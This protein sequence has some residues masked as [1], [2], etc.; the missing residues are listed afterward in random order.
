SLQHPNIL[1][2]LGQC[3]ESVPFL[4][5][6]EFCQLGD[7]KRYLRAQRKSDGMTPDLL[8]R[9]LLTLQRMAYE[10][11]SGLLHLHENNYIHSDLALRNCLLTSD[12]TVRIGDYGLSHNQ[13]K[14]DYYLTPDKLWIPLRWIAPELLEEFRGNLI[15]TDQT[16]T[17]N[18]WSLGVVIWELF[19][20]GAQPHRHL[21][22]EE[23]LTFVIR[24]RQ[25]TLA[26]PRLKLTHADYWYEVMQSCWLPP[27][28]RPTVNKVFL[29]LSSL[30]AAEQ[31]SRKSARRDEDEE[32]YDE[33][34]EEGR[35]GESDE[36]FERR[37]DAL[38]PPAF[39]S[40]AHKLMREREYGR[41]DG[42]LRENGN[43]F[44][45]LDPVDNM[46]TPT[47]E[48]D[49]ILTVTETSKG[50]NFEYFWEKAH[51]R[52]GY[53]PLPPPQP[54]PTPNS[55]HRQ[56][57]DTPTVVPVISARSPSLASEYY[58]RLE[59]HTPQDKSP[60]L[61]RGRSFKKNSMCP[62]DLELVELQTGTTGKD[63]PGFKQQ[64]GFVRGTSQTVRSSEVK[65][66][67]PNTGLVEFSKESCNRVTDY[68]VIDIGEVNQKSLGPQAPI[69]PPKPRSMSMS[70]GSHLHSRP[71][72]APPLGYART[73]GLDIY[74]GS[75]F[76]TGKVETSDSLLMSSL[77]KANF[78]HLGIN[79]THQTLPPSPSLSPSIPPS[80]GSHTMFLP[81]QTCPPPL[82]PHYRLQ[83]GQNYSSEYSRY[84]AMHL[85]RDPLSCDH[86][87]ERNADRGM[88]RSQSL[89]NS[90]DGPEL[91]TTDNESCSRMTRSQSTI[92]KIERTSSSSPE[93]SKDED[94]DDDD[95]SPFMSPHRSTSGTTIQHTNLV[96]EPDP[97]TS[98]LFSR[99]MKR[100]QSRLATILPA[101]WREDAVMQRERV[102]AARKSPIH[103]FLT[104]ISNDSADMKDGESSWARE[105]DGRREKGMRRSQSLLSELDSTSQAWASD[106][107]FLPG[108]EGSAKKRDLFLTEIE[109]SV[110]DC[111]DAYDGEGGTPVSRFGTTPHP[112]AHPSD[113]PAYT[114]AEEA[115]SSG[116][117]K[118]HSLLSEISNESVEPEP[119]K[120]EITREEFLKEIQSAET[121]LTEIITRQRKMEESVSPAPLSPEYESIC[122]DPESSQTIQFESERTRTGKAPGDTKEAIYAQVTKRAKR[123]E[124]KVAMRPEI[125][126]LQIASELQNLESAQKVTPVS[127]F[128]P[129]IQLERNSL[130][131]FLPS[132]VMPKNGPLLEQISPIIKENQN[133]Q[134]SHNQHDC[135]N[136]RPVEPRNMHNGSMSCN[137]NLITDNMKI[138]SVDENYLKGMFVQ[139]KELMQENDHSVTIGIEVM[140]SNA[141]FEENVYNEK[142]PEHPNQKPNELTFLDPT[143]NSN[144]VCRTSSTKEREYSSDVSQ[145]CPTANLQTE[146]SSQSLEQTTLPDWETSS[147]T[148]CHDKDMKTTKE[149]IL[150]SDSSLSLNESSTDVFHSPMV[151]E[152]NS[153]QSLSTMTPS[154]SVLS[155]LTS[156]SLDC[157]TPGDSWLGGGSGGWRALGTETPHRDSAYFSDSDLDGGEGLGRK[158]TDVLGP[159][160]P[161]GVRT[162]ERGILMGIE[163]KIEDEGLLENLEKE[164][165]MKQDM[166]KL[167]DSNE[168]A[169]VVCDEFIARLFSNGEDE[170]NKGVP[171]SNSSLNIQNSSLVKNSELVMSHTFS[172]ERILHDSGATDLRLLADIVSEPQKPISGQACQEE[173]IEH[174][175]YLQATKCKEASCT[176]PEFPT[177]E[178]SPDKSKSRLSRFYSLQSDYSKCI[179]SPELNTKLNN[180]DT[181]CGLTQFIW[182][183][184]KAERPTEGEKAKLDIQDTDANEL[185][186][187]NLTY[188]EESEDEQ[189]KER[190][191]SQLAVG[192]LCFTIKESPQN[193]ADENV[194]GMEISKDERSDEFGRGASIGLELKEKELWSALEED[195]STEETMRGEFNCQTFQ[196]G[197]LHLWP[198]ENDQ[199]AAAEARTPEAGLGSELFPSFGKKAWGEE[200]HLVVSHEFWESEANDELADSESHP[201]T[202]RICEDAFNDEKLGQANYPSPESPV[203]SVEAQEA[204]V[205]RP[206]FQQEENMENPDMENGTPEHYISNIKMEVENLENPE[207]EAPVQ[208][209]PVEVMIDTLNS[210]T[211]L[212][213]YVGG[214][215]FGDKDNK[216]FDSHENI[217]GVRGCMTHSPSFSVTNA[218]ADK[219]EPLQN[220]KESLSSHDVSNNV[221]RDQTEAT[222]APKSEASKMLVAAPE[223]HQTCTIDMSNATTDLA[224]SSHII[225]VYPE[226]LSTET[227]RQNVDSNHCPATISDV[228]FEK[229][230]SDSP[231]CPSLTISTDPEPCKIH[232]SNVQCSAP[233]LISMELSECA[234]S[235]HAEG[236]SSFP[237]TVH[238]IEIKTSSNLFCAA[239][240]TSTKGHKEPSDCS[241][242]VNCLDQSLEELAPSTTTHSKGITANLG[243]K[244]HTTLVQENH[245]HPESNAVDDRNSLS[246]KVAHPPLSQCSLNSIPELL[247]SEWKDL[248][249]EPLE[250]FEKLEQ[251]CCIS[252]DEETLGDLFLG[253]L[254]LLESLKRNPEQRTSGAGGIIN[255]HD[256]ADAEGKTRV[257]LKEE[258]DGISKSTTAVLQQSEQYENISPDFPGE[259]QQS[260]EKRMGKH[261][262][263]PLSPCNSTDGSKGQRS[264]SKMQAKNGLMMQVCEERL[265]YSLSENV[266]TNVLW[267]STVSDSVI[268]HPWGAPTTSS[269]EENAASK[270][271][272]ENDSKEETPPSS[273]PVSLSEPAEAQTEEMTVL[274]QP[275]VT[276]SL[277]AANQAMKA[278]LARLSLSL[279]PLALSLPLSPNAKGG[280]WEGGEH[281][282]GRRRVA[283]TGSDPDEDEEEEQEDES[284]RRVIV[285][286]ETDV[287]K[288]V[289]LRSL[290]KSPKEPVDKENRDRGRNVSFFDDVTVYLFDQE[291]PTNELSSGSTTSSPHGKSPNTD[292]FGSGSHKASKSKDHVVKPRSPTGVTSGSSSRFTMSLADELLADLEEAGEEDGLYPGG[293]GGESDGEPGENQADGGLEDIPEE[294]EVDYSGTES[295]TSIAKLR[296]SKPF[297][298]IMDKI[299]HYVGNQRKNSEVSGPVEADPEYRLIVAAN[300]LTVEIDNELNIIHKFVRDKY[301][302]RFPELESLVPNALDYIRTVKELGNNLEKCKNNETLQ[303]ILTNATIMVVS[304]TASTTQGTMLGDD[305]L[306]RL[307]EACDMALE[308][309][310]SKH[311][312]YEYVESKMSFI[313]PNISIIVG[314]STAAKI[315]GV[316][317]GLTNLSKMPACNLMLLGAQRRTLSGF[318]S[319]SLL[320]HTGYI[321][322]CDVVQSL[323]PDLRR[324]AARLVA[325]KC[326]LAAR[327][328]GFHESADGK[329]GYDLKEEI[330]RKFDK[331]QEPPP[332]KQV[333]PLPAP[334]DGQRK[335]RGGRR[336][337]KMKERLGLTEIRKHANRMTF[338][339]IEDDAYQEDLGFSLGQLGKSGSG[340]VR[341]AQVNDSTKARISKSLQR[342]LQKQSMTYG[343]KS[344]V[345]DRSSGTSSSVAFTPLQGLEIV[346]PQAAEKKVAEANQKY[347]SNMAEFLK[348]KREKDDKV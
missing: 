275:E 91:Y 80:S 259:T 2:C 224:D 269:S 320:P 335:K 68:A 76:P 139:A 104:E 324:K 219:L 191:E 337:R 304:V 264:L 244:L 136:E 202:Q 59:E 138:G 127:N 120:G 88:T 26:Q 11:T 128:S 297:A 137:K 1:Q 37:W 277:P 246:Q 294:M 346:N 25:I 123:S 257:E 334:L 148:G 64:D 78:D 296:H 30:L 151:H 45:L 276:P 93:F 229:E 74:P 284:P 183:E 119:K 38:R 35:R 239:D 12:L 203:L 303:Q 86:T 130:N 338:A 213:H 142:L 300:N 108:Y 252:G 236:P 267:G 291:T 327:V 34:S 17:S 124:I 292:G 201:S 16:K 40:A 114:E 73:Y 157:L 331:W 214:E 97:A 15:V 20:F 336:Y 96:D 249:E 314:A 23:V 84:N 111:E 172:K 126:V 315:M 134:E 95:D 339:E 278:K 132:E 266:K 210:E 326:T 143:Q 187:R 247:I 290:L 306:Q 188:S 347:F 185:G 168:R 48:L 39:Q 333:K 47:S 106:K 256:S 51:G 29:L 228:F 231:S 190:S 197:E 240:Q 144:S 61:G 66:M 198:V 217:V 205:E 318:S 268:L 282:G 18:V 319:T 100:T 75:S 323:P 242:D 102:A 344:T 293:E 237:N 207:L 230:R 233:A 14:E 340:R 234:A 265:Q 71:L 325:A 260:G 33:D 171:F 54:I 118:S 288:R 28:Q 262:P 215:L 254:D 272:Q 82:P 221:Q 211:C 309:N 301:S 248:D 109:T 81:P 206:D 281:R 7:L 79:R 322:H 101:I 348:V 311:R 295:V 225:S 56:T 251:L 329:V 50:L 321:Y 116:M 177:D 218:S 166:Q 62:G 117:K 19:E 131:D 310:Q 216:E 209:R 164:V 194:S 58:I 83:K 222:W 253:N 302:K 195:Y 72:P 170:S 150:P 280:F 141:T 99:G 208:H 307:E 49:D 46:I 273:P 181:K 285:V 165:E 283:S 241:N 274:E 135:V 189:A 5:V 32:D 204:L 178:R 85:Q 94:D 235:P 27:S 43:S 158:G 316:A 3:S 179:I 145:D 65:V 173:L 36:S 193:A 22:D 140:T 255:Q 186:L 44:P 13:Y 279:P 263:T 328:D 152:P 161:G 212:Q 312:I 103:L 176:S 162:G 63:R 153:D 60:S 332:V 67:V 200:E 159:P 271:F 125:P 220:H 289:G 69:L 192:E 245:I 184:A 147:R 112:F 98:E 6:M 89:Y 122:I 286:T 232:S 70:S 155:P 31:G 113:L 167:W 223:D 163:E 238:H 317:G 107:D 261:V 196:Q 341:Q 156:S 227:V 243:Q 121:F 287:D 129:E 41:E 57:L 174:C 175:S 21:S 55:G 146:T 270:D 53:K 87:D 345:R 154:D 105:S 299:G 24:E 182:S 199:W 90:R 52:R 8:N 92:P 77:S 115:F 308:L 180:D 9:D 305:E 133:S 258:V 110:S 160:R 10:I 169:D 330:E 149:Q 226:C 298:E 42:C 313:A 4:L 250:D 343:G 342:T